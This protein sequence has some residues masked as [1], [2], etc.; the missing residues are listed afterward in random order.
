[1]ANEMSSANLAFE[2]RALKKEKTLENIIG[3]LK[4]A[5][6]AFSGGV[7]STYLLHK[8]LQVLGSNKV[9]AVNLQ[10]G[11]NRSTSLTHLKGLAEELKAELLVLEHGLL[12]EPMVKDNSKERCY[13]CKRSIL[14]LLLN[15]AEE[16]GIAAVLDGSNADDTMDYRPGMKALKELGIKSPL[17]EAGLTKNEIRWLSAKAGLPTW[18]QPATTCLATRFPYGTSIEP[19][20]LNRVYQAEEFL[21]SLPLAG[22]LRVR[23]HNNL[24][25]VEVNAEEIDKVLENREKISSRLKELGF[26]YITLSLDDFS[27]GSMNMELLKIEE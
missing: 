17:L 9:M 3:S 6:V 13:Y 25:R 2:E 26:T 19:E 15:T 21:R 24:A 27:S 23:C 10:T 14:G 4:S 1:M 16:R 8:A 7:D 11:L 5:I 20:M 12:Q 22:D 18:D